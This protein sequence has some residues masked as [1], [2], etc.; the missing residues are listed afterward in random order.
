[1][2]DFAVSTAFKGQDHVTK[3]LMRMVKSVDKFGDHAD[4]SFRKAAASSS[5]FST[6]VKGIL[7][8]GAIQQGIG[9]LQQGVAAVAGEFLGFDDNVLSAAAKF[10]GLNLVTTQGQKQLAELKKVAR[11]VGADTE[12]SAGQAAQGLD[13]LALAGFNA[14]QAMAALPGVVDLATVAK[15]D[16]GRATDIA[17]DSLGAFGLAAQDSMKLQANLARVNNVMALTMARSNTDIEFMYEAVQKG[18][19]TFT[20]AGQS[21][22]TFNAMI[23]KMANSSLKGAEAGTAVRNVMLRLSKP[24]AEAQKALEALKVNVGE[25]GNFRDTIDILYDLEKGLKGLGSQQKTA[26]LATIFGARATTAVNI[27][28]KEGAASLRDFRQ[29][30]VDSTGA[31]KLM[32]EIMR[33]SLLNRLRALGSAAVEAGFKIF[34]AFEKRGGNAIVK[35]TEWVRNFDVKPVINAIEIAVTVFKALYHVIAPLVPILPVIAAGMVSYMAAVKIG[36]MLAFIK[37]IRSA[38]AAQG[39]LNAVMIANPIGAV[40]TAI[41]ALVAAG[42]LLYKHW[43]KIVAQFKRFEKAIVKLGNYLGIMPKDTKQRDI[44]RRFGRAGK[45]YVATPEKINPAV[46][47]ASTAAKPA[48]PPVQAETIPTGTIAP[49]KPALPPVQAKTIPTATIAP[50]KPALPP[51]PGPAPDLPMPTAGQTETNNQASITPPNR[52]EASARQINFNGRLDISGAPA[53]SAVTS[54]TSGAPPIRV[55][56][57]GDNS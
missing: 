23:G 40:I 47:I 22:E 29:E 45:Y 1:M 33:K 48:L 36:A 25:N 52:A 55:E 21:I 37:V 54:K 12:F 11:E 15:V 49:A 2:P 51:A 14:N 13:F 3:P 26:A 44:V 32:A 6:L 46:G 17:S 19:P 56:L 53:G 30:L 57:L 35:L 16:L 18:A 42:V 50:A 27:L 34:T 28:L 24:T 41:T 43:D 9:L 20:T 5:Q 10:K 38:A 39:L 7:A 31:S 8:A 4:R